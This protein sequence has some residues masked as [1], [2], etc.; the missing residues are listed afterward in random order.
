MKSLFSKINK[1]REKEESPSI[2]DSFQFNFLLSNT[3]FIL[4]LS[5]DGQQPSNKIYID[6][7]NF[8]KFINHTNFDEV[9]NHFVN[10]ILEVLKYYDTFELHMNIRTLT[11]TATEKYKDIILM[12]YDKY[13]TNYINRIDSLYIYYTPSFFDVIKT[14]FVKLSPLSN[15][16]NIEAVLYGKPESDEKLAI[17]LKDRMAFINGDFSADDEDE[18]SI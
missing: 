11:I 2:L 1:R 6:F 4:P 13:Q 12:F 18:D 17:L 5:A 14:I 7:V 16:F 3:V 10:L 9:V 15:T 8:R